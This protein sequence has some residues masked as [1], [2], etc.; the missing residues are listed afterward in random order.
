M[1]QQAAG[2]LARPVPAARSENIEAR[3]R[4]ITEIEAGIHLRVDAIEALWHEVAAFLREV[5]DK[6]LWA[7]SE[8]WKTWEDWLEHMDISRSWAFSLVAIDKHEHADLLRQLPISRARMVIAKVQGVPRAKAE[9]II[10]EC[11]A[12]PTWRTSRVAVH[13]ANPYEH[14]E[15]RVVSP[16]CNTPLLASRAVNLRVMPRQW[17]GNDRGRQH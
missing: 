1:S 3:E 13:G 12:Q 2:Q 4:R 9:A 10:G 11:A 6:Q 8:Q 15:V 7:V 5:H 16:C 14:D 17:K